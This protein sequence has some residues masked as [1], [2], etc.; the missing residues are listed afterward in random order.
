MSRVER[1]KII[2]DRC[3]EERITMGEGT[4]FSYRRY[5]QGVCNRRKEEI[6]SATA[7]WTRPPKRLNPSEV[8][9]IRLDAKRGSNIP[10]PH[11]SFGVSV[12]TDRPD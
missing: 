8:Q 4:F 12:S 10:G 1:Q 9:D 3:S 5:F 11:L 7:K 2:K 6:F